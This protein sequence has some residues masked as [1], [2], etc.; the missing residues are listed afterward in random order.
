MVLA[1]QTA[2]ITARTGNGETL[3][4][5]VE[6]VE[7]FLLNRVDGQRAGFAIDITDEHTVMVATTVTEASLAVCDRTM[8]W[9]EQALHSS[10]LQLLIISALVILH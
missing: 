8:V 4:S 2:E 10:V 7:W 1:V 9:T 5:R 3:G 6:M